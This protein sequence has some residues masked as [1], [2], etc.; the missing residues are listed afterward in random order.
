MSLAELPEPLREALGHPEAA[1]TLL[2]ELISEQVEA[3][4]PEADTFAL[5]G[6][7]LA[8]SKNL[9]ALEPLLSGAG[10]HGPRGIDL[11]S[12][13]AAN[14]I[15]RASAE[16]RAAPSNT[17]RAAL[18]LVEAAVADGQAAYELC[19]LMHALERGGVARTW[20]ARVVAA[21][22]TLMAAP[23]LEAAQRRALAAL[24]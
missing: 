9:A 21:R 6:L 17:A 11:A 18:G 2:L 7:A 10:A 22:Q 1:A 4:A 5:F 8:E 13:C 23:T 12:L 3:N 19:L 16:G 24:S 14:A 20:Q 15:R